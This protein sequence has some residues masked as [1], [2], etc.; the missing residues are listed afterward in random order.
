MTER[1]RWDQLRQQLGVSQDRAALVRLLA[2]TTNYTPLPHQARAHLAHVP[3][4]TTQKL[5]LAGIGAGKTVWSM[6]ECVMLAIANPGCLGAITAPTYDQVVNVLLPEWQALTD[7]MAA[8]GYPL[9]RRFIKSMS[10]AHLVCGGRVLFRSFGKVDHLRGFSLAWAAL[11]E[12]EVSMNPVQV[13]DVLQGRLRDPRANMRQ[14]HCT[15]TPQ[16]LRGVPAMFVEARNRAAGIQDPN[17]RSAALRR[18][19]SCTA[20]SHQNTHL[21]DGYIEALSSTYSKRQYD[22]EVLAKILK[23]STAVWPEFNKEAHVRPWAYDPSLPYAI[24]ADWGHQYPHVL[25]LQQ[26]PD[27]SWIVF[28]EFCDDQIPRD[29]LRHAIRAR[30]EALGKD[31]EHAVGDRAVKDEMA[32]LVHQ[33][34]RTWVHRMRTKQEQSVNRGIEVVRALLDPIEGSPRLYVSDRI[35]ASQARRGLIRCLQNYRYRMRADGGIHVGQPFKDNVHDHG[36]DCLRMFAV[37]VI[38]GDAG[39][40]SAGRGERGRSARTKGHRVRRR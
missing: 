3:D 14:I 12:S 21:P 30:C 29:H 38:E 18:H 26:A 8:N 13:W 32:W 24:S 27:E 1:R 33:F 25:W 9:V 17:E 7:A 11:D 36:A 35:G 10:E 23:P 22:Q 31:P 15:T 5:F 28:D 16:G 4:G 34:P 39:A 19:W 40:F 2:A 6:A 37:A 20:T